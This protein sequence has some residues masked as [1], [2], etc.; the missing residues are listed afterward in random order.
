MKIVYVLTAALLVLWMA[1]TIFLLFW[2]Y[3]STKNFGVAVMVAGYL[4]WPVRSGD[5]SIALSPGQML[6]MKMIAY[7]RT[8]IIVAVLAQVV[9]KVILLFRFW[10]E[11]ECRLRVEND[12]S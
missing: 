5:E 11:P 4:Q 12:M 7:S 9:V 8:F 2:V 1:S 10:C 3:R 6:L